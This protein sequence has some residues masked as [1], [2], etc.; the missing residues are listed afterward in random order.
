MAYDY[1][2]STNESNDKVKIPE[3]ISERDNRMESYI[4]AGEVDYRGTFTSNELIQLANH[5]ADIWGD[6]MNNYHR[7]LQ[8]KGLAYI[9]NADTDQFTLSAICW[10]SGEH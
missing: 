7:D 1:F 10:S 5:Y 6:A 4:S 3:W 8:N 9:K 2:I